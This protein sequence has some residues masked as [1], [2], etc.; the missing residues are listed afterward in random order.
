MIHCEPSQ[1]IPWRAGRCRPRTSLSRRRQGSIELRLLGGIAERD[2]TGHFPRSFPGEA[3]GEPRKVLGPLVWARGLTD[4]TER[5]PDRA[6]RCRGRGFAE[7]LVT[8]RAGKGGVVKSGVSRWAVPERSKSKG[9]NDAL[10][11]PTSAWR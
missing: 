3:L 5:S 11:D 8:Q 2:V 9:S 6:L 1:R 7:H 4:K 10:A